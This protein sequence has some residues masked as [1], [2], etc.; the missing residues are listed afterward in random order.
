MT[1]DDAERPS[2]RAG[3]IAQI[4]A[5][6]DANVTGL[7]HTRVGGS[8]SMGDVSI[9]IDMETKGHEHCEQVLRASGPRVPARRRSLGHMKRQLSPRR[10]TAWCRW[11]A[12]RRGSLRGTAGGGFLRAPAVR[13]RDHQH[14]ALLHSLDRHLRIAA[15][16]PG[17]ILDILTF[18]L[19]HANLAHLISNTLP[20]IIFGF[21]VFLSGLRVF[22]TALASSWLGSGADGVADRRLRDHRGRVRAGLRPLRVPAGPRLLQPQLVADRA[23]RGAVHGLR[24]H[25]VRRPAHRGGLRLLAGAPGRGDRRRR[26]GAAAEAAAAL[27]AGQAPRRRSKHNKTPAS[28]RRGGRRR[29]R[30]GSVRSC[31]VSLRTAWRR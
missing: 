22:L 23:L 19:L 13:D 12:P 4:I 14:G 26:R 9:T 21:L 24:R 2:R 31:S 30:Y 27:R 20:L 16:Q 29:C 17:R 18:P 28:P 7:D 25:P 1:F 6:N 15:P 5:V 3:P 8:I 10:T 11:T